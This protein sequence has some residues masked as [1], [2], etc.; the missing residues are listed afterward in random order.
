MPEYLKDFVEAGGVFE[1]RW[2][3]LETGHQGT[4]FQNAIHVGT[5]I[6]DVANE[7]TSAG[8][9]RKVAVYAL[10]DPRYRN[11]RSLEEYASIREKYQHFRA[12]SSF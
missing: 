1:K 4:V 3:I 6:Y 9:T 12:Y 2:G 10:N 7:E 5:K 11:I 8:E